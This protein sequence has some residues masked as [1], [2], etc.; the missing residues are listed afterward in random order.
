MKRCDICLST[1]CKL[2]EIKDEYATKVLKDICEECLVDLNRRLR[3]V[4][5][6]GLSLIDKWCLR[7]FETFVQSK[8]PVCTITITSTS[9]EEI[10]NALDEEGMKW[11]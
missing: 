4:K 6:I 8:M 10:A 2:S 7:V 1:N 9:E 11:I 3:K 5:E